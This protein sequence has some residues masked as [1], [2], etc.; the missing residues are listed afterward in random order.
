MKVLP[1]MA[2][3]LTAPHVFAAYGPMDYELLFLDADNVE[4]DHLIQDLAQSCRAA[5]LDASFGVA[6][7]PKNGRNADALLA[8]ANALLKVGPGKQADRADST[9]ETAPMQRV[10]NL[11][12][13]VAAS[14]INVLILGE[15]GVGKDVLAQLIH[16][17]SPRNGNP[18]VAFN[19]A[20]F[21]E[22]VLDSELFGHYR[23]SFTGATGARTGLLESANGGTVFLDEIGDMPASMQAKLLR[24]IESRE[25]RP[26]GA[27]KT[28]SIN[29]RFISA[30]NKN[31]DAEVER[32]DFR[33]DL[34]D[35]LN[36]MTLVVPPLRERT[37]E[38]PTLAET[39][40]AAACR[41]IGREP[42]IAISAAVMDHLLAYRWPGNIRELKNVVERA[43]A[44][45][46]GSHILPEHLP[47]EKMNALPV[48]PS[49]PTREMPVFPSNGLAQ[50]L[51]ALTDPDK[52]EE[53]RR[54]IEALSACHGNQTRA[55]QMLQMPR[56]TFVSKL[57]YY[58]I[59][60]PQK[61]PPSLPPKTSP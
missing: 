25:I 29:V 51:P 13:R 14:P 61:L 50:Y 19:C 40:V 8:A 48:L 57:D 46:D 30:T 7:Y 28:H 32:G 35:R 34:L 33:R 36:T 39:F 15:C 17:L 43:V 47:Q 24:A 54:I 26:I 22:G 5:G 23:G 52:V 9:T 53:R 42:T 16:R 6:W 3:V 10:R 18:Y 59:P 2:R 41:E 38:I 37:D 11:A 49:A 45:C 21:S 27:P 55:A 12:T 20:A 58:N 56:R 31:L 44:L 60:R 1:V 4:A